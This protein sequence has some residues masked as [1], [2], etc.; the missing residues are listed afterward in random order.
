MARRDA[1]VE[2]ERSLRVPDLL[3][4]V[5]AIRNREV[6]RTQ[7]LLGVALPVPIFDRNQGNILAAQRRVEQAR[8]AAR[9]AEIRLHTALAELYERL[10]A[11]RAQLGILRDDVLPGAQGALEAANR[12]YEG[13]RVGFLEVLDAQRT[14]F[15][16]RAQ[17]LAVLSA[18]HRTA[19]EVERT[20]AADVLA[21]AAP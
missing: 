7:A 12:A 16:A 10:D 6:G 15:D 1:L 11:A 17:Y 9:A 5:G 3:V 2:L 20:L 14:L 4:S 21:P 18:V 13:G 19:A 8:D